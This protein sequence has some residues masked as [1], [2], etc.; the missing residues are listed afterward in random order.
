MLRNPNHRN[1]YINNTQQIP[2][3]DHSLPLVRTTL[4][5]LQ[6]TQTAPNIMGGVFPFIKALLRAL[7]SPSATH[8]T[9]L[10]KPPIPPVSKL[11]IFKL[12][13]SPFIIPNSLSFSLQPHSQTIYQFNTTYIT[14]NHQHHHRNPRTPDSNHNCHTTSIQPSHIQLHRQMR[15]RAGHTHTTTAAVIRCTMQLLFIC[16]VKL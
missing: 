5:S 3:H 8:H 16:S 9:H 13:R 11:I 2:S 14:T 15:A 10:W 4:N 12:P 1:T 6:I 7:Y